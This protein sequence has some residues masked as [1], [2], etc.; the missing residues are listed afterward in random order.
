MTY[1]RPHQLCCLRVHPPRRIHCIRPIPIARHA[2]SYLPSTMQTHFCFSVHHPSTVTPLIY[3]ILFCTTNTLTPAPL[4]TTRMLGGADKC[5]SRLWAWFE[6]RTCPTGASLT[7]FLA[8]LQLP[9]CFTTC[10]AWWPSTLPA[11]A[12]HARPR[13]SPKTIH[14]SGAPG[15]VVRCGVALPPGPIPH[16][17]RFPL[18][19]AAHTSTACGRMP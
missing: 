19:A 5:G 3:M 2:S 14:L 12:P 6:R 8:L 13:A 9:C 4:H 16:L 17:V 10:S 1:R 18:P 11:D 7:P 15:R